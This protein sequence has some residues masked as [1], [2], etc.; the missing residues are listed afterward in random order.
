VDVEATF[1]NLAAEFV[2][3]QSEIK[4][5]EAT[6]LAS[7]QRLDDMLRREAE[8]QVALRKVFDEL[9]AARAEL[10]NAR[11]EATKV[12]AAATARADR[13]LAEARDQ[14][15]DYLDSIQAAI[16]AAAT[17]AIRGKSAA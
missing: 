13:V 10:D 12:M 15:A 9:S 7:Q 6:R 3:K 4:A 16:N 11:R 1:K 5:L 17:T 2:A 14:A 8:A